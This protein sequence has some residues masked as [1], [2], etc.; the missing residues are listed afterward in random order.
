MDSKPTKETAVDDKVKQ[1]GSEKA[2]ETV[3]ETSKSSK[4]ERI[5]LNVGGV[6]V[7]RRLE[8][9]CVYT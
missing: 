6:K 7:R 2:K 4:N 5:I 8:G 3:A 1:S 9:V